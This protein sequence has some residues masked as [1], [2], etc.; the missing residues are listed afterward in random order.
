VSYANAESDIAMFIG[1]E[2][3][4]KTQRRLVQSYDFPKP[5]GDSPIQ[6]VGVDGA[7][8]RL[9][10][11][12]GEA[13]VWRDYKAIATEQGIVAA[14]QQNSHLINW[15]NQ[16]PL[17]LPLTCLGD[18]HDGVWKIIGAIATLKER[19]EVLDW[20]HL[21]ENLQK[22]GGSLKRLREAEALLWKGQVDKSI[23]LFQGVKSKQAQNFWLCFKEVWGNL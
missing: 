14:F 19:R 13:C 16:Q 21:N 6:E 5:E 2:V 18:G 8:V 11:S 3:S 1:M 12:L 20:Y 10:T 23:A 4:S 22:V 17:G 9:R 7:K 15:I